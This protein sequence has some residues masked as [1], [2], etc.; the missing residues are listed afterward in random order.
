[1]ANLT[2]TLSESQS[3]YIENAMTTGKY[4]SPAE[5]VCALLDQARLNSG[6][7][8][9]EKLIDEGVASGPAEKFTPDDWNRIRQ[10]VAAGSGSAK[11]RR[12]S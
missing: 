11:R 5:V 2:I 3:K 8:R 6:T 1:M 10:E 12:R 9:L 4:S 7:E